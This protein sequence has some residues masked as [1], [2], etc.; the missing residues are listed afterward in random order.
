MASHSVL[1]EG[2][3][4][5]PAVFAAGVPGVSSN[6]SKTLPLPKEKAM[7]ASQSPF[8]CRPFVSVVENRSDENT[9]NQQPDTRGGGVVR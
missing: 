3:P 7:A 8:S 6:F 1:N 9:I 2:V 5:A 4:D